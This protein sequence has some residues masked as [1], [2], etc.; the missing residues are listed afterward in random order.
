MEGGSG[1][2][3]G[4]PPFLVCYITRGIIT[5]LCGLTKNLRTKMGAKRDEIARGCT[6]FVQKVS[7]VT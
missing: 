7:M 3:G 1:G 4:N 5:H 6:V 2:R